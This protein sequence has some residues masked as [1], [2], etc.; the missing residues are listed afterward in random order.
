MAG[1]KN[2]KDRNPIFLLAMA[3]EK[4]RIYTQN[5]NN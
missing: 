1:N 5:T 4:L 2:N 3:P